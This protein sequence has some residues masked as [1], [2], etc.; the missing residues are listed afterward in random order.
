MRKLLSFL[1]IMLLMISCDS[2]RAV[3]TN[4]VSDTATSAEG[5]GVHRSQDRVNSIE[6]SITASRI[7][8]KSHQNVVTIENYS[9]KRFL[10]AGKSDPVV[11]DDFI[12]GKIVDSGL[13]PDSAEAAVVQFFDDYRAGKISKNPS[14]YFLGEN[15]TLLTMLFEEWQNSRFFPTA[16]RVGNGLEAG[17]EAKVTARCFMGSGDCIC[18]FVMAK[19]GGKW[20]VKSFSGNLEEMTAPAEKR[21]EFE[22]EVYYFF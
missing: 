6:Q 13:K 15:R 1:I 5:E 19:D 20:K 11:P 16:V 18:E 14:N 17:G 21:E 2:N 3:S 9:E 4:G 8:K 7:K 22:P 12:I 10:M